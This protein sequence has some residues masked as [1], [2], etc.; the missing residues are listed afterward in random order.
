MKLT[1][2]TIIGILNRVPGNP[3]NSEGA[4]LP[5]E[6]GRVAFA[7]SRYFGAS[8]HDGGNC[9]ICVIYSNDGGTTFDTEH[10]ET[11]VEAAEYGE[12]NVMS[13][14]L[15]RMNNGDIGLFY[16]LKHPGTTSEY[17]LRRYRGDFSHPC[18]ETKCFPTEYDSY[19]VIN[20]DRVCRRSDGTWLIPAA[21]HHTSHKPKEGCEGYTSP[22]YVDEKGVLR[23]EE[24]YFDMRASVYFFESKDDGATWQQT[25]GVLHMPDGYSGTGLQEPGLIELP[26]GVLYCYSRTDR[27]YQYESVS[28]DG[29]DHWFAPQPSRFTSPDSPM[30]IKQ[31]PHSGKYYAVWNPAPRHAYRRQEYPWTAGR[32][33]LVLAE[34]TDG[35]HF[36]QPVLIEDDPTRGYCYPAMEFLDDKTILLA[37]CSG[38]PEEHGNLNRTVIRKLTIESISEV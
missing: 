27:M 24:Y 15:R 16:M 11:L 4:F 36:S 26:G 31:N 19:F 23:F 33:P 10:Y 3:R 34:S 8:D 32:E 12:R 13:V 37:Y 7:Y 21:Y 5:L 25:T 18:G 35:V 28:I 14:T 30:L 17:R 22:W 9:S 1:E 38:G 6:D 2:S 20:N 29:G